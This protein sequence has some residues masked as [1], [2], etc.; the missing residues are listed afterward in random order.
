MIALDIKLA[1]IISPR[2]T[3]FFPVS[4]MLFPAAVI[5]CPKTVHFLPVLFNSSSV[6][7]NSVCWSAKATRDSLTLI[8]FFAIASSCFLTAFSAF[9]CA[10]FVSS[11]CAFNFLLSSLSLPVSLTLSLY[12]AV[13]SATFSFNFCSVACN[14]VSFCFCAVR[15]VCWSLIASVCSFILAGNSV[16]LALSKSVWLPN[17]FA[18]AAS[19]LYSLVTSFICVSIDFIWLVNSLVFAPTL[20]LAPAIYITYSFACVSLSYSTWNTT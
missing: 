16:C 4:S 19:T 10:S 11:S 8:V 1:F 18:C 20:R 13:S 5:S 2:L 7:F 9:A 17:A 12:A 15:F 6:R 14:S 3:V